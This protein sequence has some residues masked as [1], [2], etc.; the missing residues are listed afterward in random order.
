M[1]LKDLLKDSTSKL[2]SS[3]FKQLDREIA[4]VLLSEL[5][6]NKRFLLWLFTNYEIT[7]IMNQGEL[8]PTVIKD[9]LIFPGNVKRT[10][11]IKQVKLDKKI[12]KKYY[13]ADY[14]MWKNEEASGK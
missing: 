10:L 12:L 11:K 3:Y 2:I 4:H 9:E 13:K 8:K 6:G 5:V 7:L 14:E 1:Q